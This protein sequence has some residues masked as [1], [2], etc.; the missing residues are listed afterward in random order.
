[1]PRRLASLLAALAAAA[2]AGPAKVPIEDLARRA[3]LADRESAWQI[4]LFGT[5]QA[6]PVQVRGFLRTPSGTGDSYAW[7]QREADVWLRWPVPAPRVA[8]LD[9]APAAGLRGQ[10]VTVLLNERPVGRLELAEGR[11]RYRLGLPAEAQ[12]AGDNTLAFRFE[13]AAP[14][15]EPGRR[16]AAAFYSLTVGSEQDRGLE[17]LLAKNAPA[18]FSITEAGAVV[19]AGP[20]ILAYGLRLPLDAELRFTPGLHRAAREAGGWADLRVGLEND[21]GAERE[22]WHGRVDGR[23]RPTEVRVPLPGRPGEIVRLA[24]RVDG[25]PSGRFAWAVWDEPR[26]LGRVPEAPRAAE[27]DRRV[28]ELRPSLAGVNVL[29]IVLDAAGARH[30]RCYGYARETTPEIDRLADEGVLFERAFTPAVFTLAAMSSLWT[31]LPPDQ[32]HRGVAHDAPLPEGPPTLAERLTAGGIHTAGFVANGMAGVSFGLH[33]GFKE[34]HEIYRDRGR[35]AEAFLEALTSFFNAN[36]GQRFFVYAHFREPHF[37]YDPEPPFDTRFGPDGPLTLD[38]RRYAAWHTRVNARRTVPTPEQA[39][40]L[41]RLY[42]GNLAYAD[43]VIG[44]LRRRLEQEGLWDRTVVIVSAD[45]GEALLEHGFISHG[46][47]LYDESTWIPLVVRFPKGPRGV[48]VTSFVD[49]QALAPTIADVMGLAGRDGRVPPFASGSLLPVVFGAPGREAVF[50]RTVGERPQ[51]ALRDARFRFV[52]NTRY[53]QEELYD[54]DKDPGE[55]ANIAR[56]RG[57]VA[58]YYRQTLAQW[59]RDLQRGNVGEAPKPEL[60]REVLEN[61]KTLG[62]VR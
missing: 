26:V 11:G 29:L 37:P 44:T 40:H 34:F 21:S 36:K 35:R 22:V 55:Q 18:P 25:P 33:R 1:V 60:P 46:Q 5:P 20:S 24:L 6:E 3:P 19:Q 23:K 58:G 13:R 57:V 61:L 62:Y 47:Q 45:H 32:S 49:L 43:H 4:V 12:R 31:G 42:D 59:I 41:V 2:C 9:L 7:G 14:T 8:L 27:T 50:S 30:F 48:R 16:V 56:T 51:Y 38:E 17:D 10:T 28:A 53:G 54:L 39:A 52:F 15:A